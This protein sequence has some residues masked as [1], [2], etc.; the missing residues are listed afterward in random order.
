[1]NQEQLIKC[2]L[3][4]LRIEAMPAEVATDFLTAPSQKMSASFRKTCERARYSYYVSTN[5]PKSLAQKLARR[6]SSWKIDRLG[7]QLLRTEQ[8]ILI[9]RGIKVDSIKE[10]AVQNLLIP[11]LITEKVIQAEIRSRETIWAVQAKD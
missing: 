9:T 5:E 1:M 6:F 3:R 7:R 4:P 10:Q 11:L 2:N 8:R